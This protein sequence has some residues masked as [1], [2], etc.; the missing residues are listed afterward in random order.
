MTVVHSQS[1]TARSNVLG[2]TVPTIP[3]PTWLH[4]AASLPGAN[5]FVAAIAIN[6]VSGSQFVIDRAGCIYK[7]IDQG[8]N[9]TRVF[10]SGF[11]VEKSPDVTIRYSNGVLIATDT[12]TIGRVTRST[13]DGVTWSA[14]INSNL[15]KYAG[16]LASNG[17]GRWIA[18]SG[19]SQGNQNVSVSTDNG[20]TWTLHA[21]A[22]QG[23]FNNSAFW[24]GSKF[25][26]TGTAVDAVT[27][28]IYESSD[29]FTHTVYVMPSDALHAYS[30][31]GVAQLGSL[32]VMA[33]INQNL[34]KKAAT[35]TAMTT[36]SDT[37]TGYIVPTRQ[38]GT[39]MVFNSNGKIWLI[40]GNI[41]GFGESLKSTDGVSWT[42][43]TMPVWSSEDAILD[44]AFDP[45]DLAIHVIG[46]F[47]NNKFVHLE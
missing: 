32:Y 12:R 38:P 7:S 28:S 1:F 14:S 26:V 23:F 2:L 24:N 15:G 47:S 43:E 35:L 19:F 33:R 45:L 11:T 4:R 10:N 46:A 25:I 27:T 16:S 13:D 44:A 34:Y 40:G 29:G 9:W 30:N 5:T 17:S 20:L 41:N 36:A 6:Q 37:A 8:F 42:L 22:G 3:D 18:Y 39:N 31:G 21:S